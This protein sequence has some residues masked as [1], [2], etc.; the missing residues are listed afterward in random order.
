MNDGPDSHWV[1]FYEETWE[2]W[3][4]V[5]DGLLAEETCLSRALALF[6]QICTRNE[7]RL[8]AATGGSD[9]ALELVPTVRDDDPVS[10]IETM[11]MG[12]S[13]GT[14]VPLTKFV[15]FNFGNML[16]SFA[17]GKQAVV[18]LGA[19]YGRQLFRLWLSGGP[20][21]ASYYGAECTASGR[22]LAE[23]FARLACGMTF[24]AVGSRSRDRTCLT[25]RGMTIF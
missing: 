15:E 22:K 7:L 5:V 6:D 12:Y 18:E 23:R 8:V 9:Y 24:H 16:A 3:S 20:R 4:Q 10:A 19:G 13:R 25:L 11:V 14:K 2:R 17:L 21:Q 1:R